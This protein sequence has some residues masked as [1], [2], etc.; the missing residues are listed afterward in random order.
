VYRSCATPGD[1]A[2]AEQPGAAGP[3]NTRRPGCPDIRGAQDTVDDLLATVPVSD[4]ARADLRRRMAAPGRHYHGLRHL[5][6]LW[7]RHL[8]LGRGSVLHEPRL[9]RMVAAAIAFHDAVL[10]PGRADNERASAAL[11]REAAAATVPA[12]EIAWV[13]GTIEATADHLAS[14]EAILAEGAPTPLARARLWMLDL[15]LTPLGE[16]PAAFAR[17]TRLLR[18]ECP[19]LDDDGWARRL[20]AFLA[21]LHAAPRLYRTPAVGAAFEARAKANIER[22]LSRLQAM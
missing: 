16:A 9:A 19:G 6:V 7:T 18:L 3:V 12:E 17:N 15:D 22:A 5:A 14:A 8:V 4:I 20:R 21:R 10:E 11:W 2:G 13:A 1:S